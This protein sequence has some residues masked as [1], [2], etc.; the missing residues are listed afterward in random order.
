MPTIGQSQTF[1]GANSV[2]HPQIVSFGSNDPSVSEELKHP[3][4]AIYPIHQCNASEGLGTGNCAEICGKMMGRLLYGDTN[5]RCSLSKSN[6]LEYETLYHT[7]HCYARS[8]S[9][10]YNVLGAR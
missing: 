5:S 10:L 8:N 3:I 4:P 9:E 1:Y 6:F 2:T 7:S